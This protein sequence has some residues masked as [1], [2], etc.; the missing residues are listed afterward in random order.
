MLA[1]KPCLKNCP[2][3]KAKFD[4]AD[5]F[6]SIG[7]RFKMDDSGISTWCGSTAPTA[8]LASSHISLSVHLLETKTTST[9]QK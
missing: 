8:H 2:F 5:E 3:W 1:Q 4:S 9:E 7:A 6:Y